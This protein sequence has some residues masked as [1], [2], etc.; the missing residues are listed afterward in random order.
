MKRLFF[1][2]AAP[3]L[4]AGLVFS[5]QGGA[6]S[7]SLSPEA[8]TQSLQTIQHQITVI[9]QKFADI[10]ADLT[11][12]KSIS[13]ET[14]VRSLS[15]LHSLLYQTNTA[16]R[17]IN[18]I[19]GQSGNVTVETVDAENKLNTAAAQIIELRDALF[20][21]ERDDPIHTTDAPEGVM[22]DN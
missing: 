18:D 21:P 12:E 17:K 1:K 13:E 6:A 4:A 8:N 3:A 5:A 19:A 10:N 9:D 20:L 14:R 2:A 22:D 7:A 15:R 11:R 16:T